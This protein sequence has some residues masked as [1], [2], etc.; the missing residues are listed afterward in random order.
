MANRLGAVGTASHAAQLNHPSQFSLASHRSDSS[1]IVFPGRKQESRRRRSNQKVKRLE[2][3]FE[4]VTMFPDDESFNSFLEWKH[5]HT[6]ADDTQLEENRIIMSTL[7][8]QL[9]DDRSGAYKELKDIPDHLK[10]WQSYS[11]L[12]REFMIAKYSILRGERF[13]G[14]FPWTH[15]DKFFKVEN[16]PHKSFSLSN[17]VLSVDNME[18]MAKELM[19]LKISRK[20]AFPDDKSLKSYLS[21][22]MGS[23][24]EENRDILR[25][26][27]SESDYQSFLSDV[28]KDLKSILIEDF[29]VA[30]YSILE[31]RRF[32]NY[33]NEMIN[34]FVI[35]QHKRYYSLRRLAGEDCS[36]LFR[37]LETVRPVDFFFYGY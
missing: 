27:F 2:I 29:L 16:W 24:W 37:N 21:R 13:T 17:V 3:Q 23:S 36:R 33:R 11:I 15:F 7:I 28:P 19:K 1:G 4:N 14:N 10:R 9:L 31:K 12:I 30:K 8:N 26:L 35:G 20:A 18:Q 25:M 34:A 32:I 6:S 22:K 5:E